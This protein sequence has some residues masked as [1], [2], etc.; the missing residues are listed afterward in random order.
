MGA[1]RRT[2]EHEGRTRITGRTLSALVPRL[3]VPTFRLACVAYRIGEHRVCVFSFFDC[4]SDRI[5][6]GL[7]IGE[8]GFGIRINLVGIDFV[9]SDMLTMSVTTYASLTLPTTS[10][11]M[12]DF[13]PV[14]FTIMC[15]S[16]SPPPRYLCRSVGNFLC[17]W[18][19]LAS[20][21]PDVVQQS[22]KIREKKCAICADRKLCRTHQPSVRQGGRGGVPHL[23]L[24]SGSLPL[25]RL[26]A[27]RQCQQY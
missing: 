27:I 20:L 23:A 14:S 4:G 3:S 6:I 25:A 12:V 8:I 7:F 13:F 16:F 26:T 9:G 11:T 2:I 1:L 22:L 17:L 15:G 21:L 24:L 19:T 10:L 18:P 5:N